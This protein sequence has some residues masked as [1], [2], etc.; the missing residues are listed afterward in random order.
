MNPAK[1]GVNSGLAVPA[2]LVT[3]LMLVLIAQH[4]FVK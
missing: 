1:T 4:T 2:P 3:P